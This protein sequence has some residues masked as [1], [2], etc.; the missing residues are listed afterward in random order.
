M[1]ENIISIIKRNPEKIIPTIYIIM[2]IASAF[3]YFRKKDYKH[4][5]YWIAAAVITWSVTY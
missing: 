2:S 1:L 3:I 5:I 4:G